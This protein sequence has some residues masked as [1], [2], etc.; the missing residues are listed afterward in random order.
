MNGWGLCHTSWLIGLS[1]QARLAQS[2]AEA[3]KQWLTPWRPGSLPR[4]DRLPHIWHEGLERSLK[5]QL[6]WHHIWADGQRQW[7]DQAATQGGLDATPWGPTLLR[8][9]C[10]PTEAVS[11]VL[12][13]TARAWAL[14][15]A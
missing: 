13:T 6:Q 7:W 9:L 12:E 14:H 3:A 4:A 2:Q 5:Q 10:A 15:P 8:Q 11:R 1:T